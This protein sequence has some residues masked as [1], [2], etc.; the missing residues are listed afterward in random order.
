MTELERARG[1]IDRI[2][3]DMAA[4]FERRMRVCAA[5]AGE[6]KRLG[7]AVY[8]ETRESEM[9]ETRTA[10]LADK[11]LAPYYAE[12]LRAVTALSR[13]YQTD[14]LDGEEEKP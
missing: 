10:A 1:E 3:T 11:R 14:R 5:I 7:L 2:D 4:L 13:K 9:L 8:D 12:F 6:K